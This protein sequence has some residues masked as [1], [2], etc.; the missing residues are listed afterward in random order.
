M[1]KYPEITVELI[2]EDGNAFMILGKVRN[3]LRKSGIAKEEIDQFTT[4][5][6]SGDY[7][8]V[9]ATVM[10]WVEVE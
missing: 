2:G 6:T 5:A 7:D 10:D 8:N 4:E 3:A 9:L 1:P